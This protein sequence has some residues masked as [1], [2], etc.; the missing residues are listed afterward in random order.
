MKTLNQI[1]LKVVLGARGLKKNSHKL[2]Q[3][4]VLY[5]EK[6]TSEKWFRGQK[7]VKQHCVPKFSIAFWVDYNWWA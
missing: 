7:E 4:I 3:K 6:M 2:D 5:E 1:L